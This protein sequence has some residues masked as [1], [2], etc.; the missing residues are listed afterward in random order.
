MNNTKSKNPLVIYRKCKRLRSISKVATLYGLSRSTVYGLLDRA[1][2]LL[3]ERISRNG[4]FST[5]VDKLEISCVCGCGKKVIVDA[6]P[7]NVVKF[8]HILKGHEGYLAK[9]R[10][11]TQEQKDRVKGK[12]LSESHRRKISE[13]RKGYKPSKEAIQKW[14]DSMKKRGFSHLRT[15][16]YRKKMREI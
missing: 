9:G 10:K 13:A 3:G 12:K 6:I 1:F 4:G 2:S 14:K 11:W 7:K 16:E 8:N 15:K 5:S